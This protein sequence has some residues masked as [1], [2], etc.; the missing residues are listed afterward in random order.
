[1]DYN[2]LKVV[3][4]KELLKERGVSVVGKKQTLV[5]ALNDY[6]AENGG[7]ELEDDTKED[8][9]KAAAE[10]EEQDAPKT[11]S[12]RAKRKATSPVPAVPAKPP[13][14]AKADSVKIAIKTVTPT[15]KTV[16]PTTKTAA[17][18]TKTAPADAQFVPAGA[19][20]DIPVDDGVEPG[21]HVFVDPNSGIIYDASLNQTNATNNNNKFYR[22]QV[23]LD[24]IPY[25]HRPFHLQ[26]L[27]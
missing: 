10:K 14:K 8:D 25:K 4:L 17:P 22:V 26:P 13:K 27:T 1:M 2:T 15:I 20:L 21:Y 16:T 24:H 18:T 6:D 5:D 11:R 7:D 9:V 12:T 19:T 3:E 23:S